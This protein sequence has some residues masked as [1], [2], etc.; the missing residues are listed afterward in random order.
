MQC[1]LSR[2]KHNKSDGTKDGKCAT[3]QVKNDSGVAWHAE[4]LFLTNPSYSSATSCNI[5]VKIHDLPSPAF[6]SG[7]DK[8]TKENKYYTLDSNVNGKLTST[9][10]FLLLTTYVNT[11]VL[12]LHVHITIS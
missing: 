11:Y 2:R 9:I 5:G 6:N 3:G 12:C 7:S 8:V 10:C 4:I 1:Q